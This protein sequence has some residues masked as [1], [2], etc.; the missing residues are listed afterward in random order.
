MRSVL[1]RH[2]DQRLKSLFVYSDD[3]GRFDFGPNHPFKPE[4][5]T[6]T[7]DLC[8]RYGVMNYPWMTVLR[9]ETIDE[10]LLL[11]YH[12]PEYLKLLR[13]ASEGKVS[14]EMLARGLGTEDTPILRGIMIPSWK[15]SL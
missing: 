12:E 13:D 7:Y 3:M 10:D 9:P 1:N 6:K 4:R 14:I 15:A 11:L 8:N 5:A 2:P